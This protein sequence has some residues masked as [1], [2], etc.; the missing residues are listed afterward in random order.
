[1]I[2]R[3][4]RR[5]AAEDGFTLMELVV[6]I[7]MTAVVIAALT[8]TL[9]SSAG[10]SSEAQDASSLQLQMRTA[11]SQLTTD[12][13]E[14]YTGSGAITPVESVT[15][16]T[17]SFYAPDRNTPFRLRHIWYRFVNGTLQ[18]AAVSTTNTG[19]STT[20]TWPSTSPAWTDEVQGLSSL[21]FTAYAGGSPPAPATTPDTIRSV[22]VTAS[23]RTPGSKGR[24]YD[25][26]Q[27]VG[28]RENAS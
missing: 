16:T 19:P 27:T 14:A 28:L 7:P 13:R 10:F 6:A 4:R 25:F 12:L 18:R 22:V 1:M 11:M 8:L 5:L 3:L 2:G 20:W 21:S 24:A 15:A 17:L 26:Q 23:A 9:T